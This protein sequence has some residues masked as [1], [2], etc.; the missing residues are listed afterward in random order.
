MNGSGN[1]APPLASNITEELLRAV[2]ACV[3]VATLRNKP[4]KTQRAY[5]TIVRRARFFANPSVAAIL[6]RTMF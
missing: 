5:N 2:N 1:A 4:P 3:R 6:A